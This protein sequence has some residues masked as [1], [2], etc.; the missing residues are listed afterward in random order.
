MKTTKQAYAQPWIIDDQG[1]TA[2]GL[3]QAVGI[4]R[5][6]QTIWGAARRI[7][8]SAL[9]NADR[10]LASSRHIGGTARGCDGRT[11]LALPRSVIG[12]SCATG[13]RRR[14][15]RKPGPSVV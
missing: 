9:P 3:G 11:G 12:N 15:L 4:S 7:P 6:I 5:S 14:G 1:A 8:K 13:W 10:N 2:T